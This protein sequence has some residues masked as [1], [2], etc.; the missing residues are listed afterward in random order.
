MTTTAILVL[1]DSACTILKLC[2]EIQ[3]VL[4]VLEFSAIMGGGLSLATMILQAIMMDNA[5]INEAG[6][7]HL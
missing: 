5:L 6:I 7:E 1:G 4:G 2:G 3:F